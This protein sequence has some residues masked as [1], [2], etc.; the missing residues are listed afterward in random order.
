MIHR[1]PCCSFH[2][3]TLHVI[4]IN[5]SSIP[6]LELLF[7]IM[8]RLLLCWPILLVLYSFSQC[9]PLFPSLS[10]FLVLLNYFVSI[11]LL[12][13]SCII[14]CKS[15]NARY[16][17]LYFRWHHFLCYFSKTS[18]ICIWTTLLGTW[19]QWQIWDHVAS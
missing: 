7:F 1:V 15:H 8:M 9:L 16:H 5:C 10:F 6:S 19:G 3:S 2:S 11:K 4:L 13:N 17:V 12:T 18:C 14:C